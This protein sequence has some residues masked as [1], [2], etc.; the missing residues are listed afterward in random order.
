M[1]GMSIKNLDEYGISKYRKEEIKM[2]CRQYQEKKQA[3]AAMLTISRAGTQPR[4][5]AGPGDTVAATVA[6]RETLLHD[7][8]M[9]DRCAQ[10]VDGGRWRDALILNVC[11][12]VALEKIPGHTLAS[13][14]RNAYFAA[15]R[16]FIVALDAAL[17]GYPPPCAC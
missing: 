5:D 1:R 10:V 8:D 3:A 6:R 7:V 13:G 2:F 9:I 4:R 12:G 11:D 17:R 16:A 15:R 14:N